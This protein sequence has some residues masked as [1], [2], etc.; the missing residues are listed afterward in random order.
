[1]PAG[2]NTKPLIVYLDT[3]DH[4]K[5]TKIAAKEDRSLSYLGGQ[6]VKVWLGRRHCGTKR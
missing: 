2:P 5:L 4:E 6:A 3:A 1:V